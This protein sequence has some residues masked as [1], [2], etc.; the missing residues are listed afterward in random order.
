MAPLW[1]NHCWTFQPVLTPLRCPLLGNQWNFFRSRRYNMNKNMNHNDLHNKT[2]QQDLETTLTCWQETSPGEAVCIRFFSL[3]SLF[4]LKQVVYLVF[5]TNI[6]SKWFVSVC[7]L[8]LSA[9]TSPPVRG[10]TRRTKT[11]FC[12]GRI[13]SP[14]SSPT[15]LSSAS[16]TSRGG[17]THT[18][19]HTSI[20]RCDEDKLE[21]GGCVML[22]NLPHWQINVITGDCRCPTLLRVVFTKAF[23]AF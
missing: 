4:T 5:F 9:H 7:F 21:A 19:T 15:G 14:K 23:S 11:V 8:S 1:A 12:G 20:F 18:H 3:R 2:E 22:W 6:R 16:S 13:S 10:T 17:E